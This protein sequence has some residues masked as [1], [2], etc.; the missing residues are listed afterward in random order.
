MISSVGIPLVIWKFR[1]GIVIAVIGGAGTLAHLPPEEQHNPDHE[2]DRYDQWRSQRR[3]VGE[4]A[5]SFPPTARNATFGLSIVP[6]DA[7]AVLTSPA[8]SPTLPHARRRR[9]RI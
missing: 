8:T 9:G 6:H 2:R 5:G 4:H 3:Q 7:P 1:T